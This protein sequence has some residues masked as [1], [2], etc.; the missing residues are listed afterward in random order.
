MVFPASSWGDENAWKSR[1]R[2][3]LQLRDGR[4][5]VKPFRYAADPLCLSACG[6][7]AVNR[8]WLKSWIGGAFLRGHFND[9]LLIPAALPLVLW[10]HAR[11]GWRQGDEMPGAPEIA[12][13]T[14]IWAVACEW[15]G[16]RFI[17]H[18]V[19]DVAD[20]FCYAAG[21]I[22]AGLWWNRSQLGRRRP[23]A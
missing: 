5:A 13:H 20:V 8:L 18:S 16:P 9:L 2:A 11:L 12:L 15:I 14:G 3:G 19:G 6:A 23:P 21:A 1:N 17:H 4:A 7:Y 10:L 22:A